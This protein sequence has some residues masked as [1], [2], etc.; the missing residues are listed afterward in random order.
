MKIRAVSYLIALLSLS[1]CRQGFDVPLT[2][3]YDQN[4]SGDFAASAAGCNINDGRPESVRQTCRDDARKKELEVAR[5]FSTAFQFDPACA[6]L[7]LLVSAPKSSEQARHSFG[8]LHDRDHWT[9]FVD[10]LPD[11]PRHSWSMSHQWHDDRRAVGEG[12]PS[13]MARSVC[14]FVRNRGGSVVN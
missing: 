6:G 10:F 3:V 1:G 7:R 14:E 13:S 2:I 9:L 5:K 12:D 8:E 11:L 4:W